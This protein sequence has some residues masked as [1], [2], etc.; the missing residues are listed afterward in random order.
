MGGGICRLCRRDPELHTLVYLLL[1][2]F[3]SE[4]CTVDEASHP[5]YVCALVLFQIGD[6]LLASFGQ[7]TLDALYWTATEKHARR[8]EH[9]WTVCAHY[10]LA[11]VYIYI[12]SVHGDTVCVCVCSK[13]RAIL[14]YG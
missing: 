9:A 6:K 2:S 11:M 8:R 5:V 10:L 4:L 3:T 7:D 13:F 14:S 1:I 12:L